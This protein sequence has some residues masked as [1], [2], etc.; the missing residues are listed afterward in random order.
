MPCIQ[1]LSRPLMDPNTSSGQKWSP[2]NFGDMMST[3]LS[4]VLDHKNSRYIHLQ[5]LTSRID[6]ACPAF[7]GRIFANI[8]TTGSGE[9]PVERDGRIYHALPRRRLLGPPNV[10]RPRPSP[11]L[12][13]LVPALGRPADADFHRLPKWQAGCGLRGMGLMYARNHDRN[14]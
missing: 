13:E 3:I 12:D 9:N 6:S 5:T 7:Y 8:R 10:R 1:G 4:E 14:R 2:E 11:L